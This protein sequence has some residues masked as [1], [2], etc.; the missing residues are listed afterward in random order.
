[1]KHWIPLAVLAA[2]GLWIAITRAGECPAGQ[3]RAY[4]PAVHAIGPTV[5]R[6]TQP[7]ATATT[8]PTNT[9][10]WTPVPDSPNESLCNAIG[11]APTDGVQAWLPDYNLA[12]G[13][14]TLLCVRF[15]Q[16]GQPVPSVIT[17]ATA[18]Y[19]DQ[20][21]YLGSEVTRE[22]GI[23]AIPFTVAPVAPG[24]L[25]VIDIEV[26]FAG[27]FYGTTTQFFSQAVPTLTL[28][29]TRTPTITVT[30]TSTPTRTNTPTN[31]P[32][33]S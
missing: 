6:T 12:P 1:M 7:E 23:L 15:T 8:G 19:P 20:D 13:N 24:Q 29:P 33:I 14:Q 2:L 10:T 22:S 28:T 16:G 32:I 30:I 11:P 27:Q 4:V 31:T 18:H 3:C 21:R 9:P 26:Q 25:V 17:R 5:T